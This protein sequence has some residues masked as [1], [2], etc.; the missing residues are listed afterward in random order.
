MGDSSQTTNSSQQTSPWAQAMPTVNALFGGVNS[1]LGNTGLTGAQSGAI[2]QLTQMGHAGN[3][4]AGASQ[5]ALDS[6]LHGGG[7]QTYSPMV[8][9]AYNTYQGQT[10]PL[11]SNTNYDPMQTPGLGDQLQALKDSITTG[12]NGQFAAAGRDLSGYNQK[13]LGSGLSAGLA[14]ILTQQY[15]QNVQNQQ[16]AAANQFGAGNTEANTLA[17]MQQQGVNNQNT[18]INNTGTVLNNSMWGPQTTLTA[19][20]L[21]HS[22]PTSNLAS[23][24]NIGIPLASLGSNSS[25]T[26]TTQNSP[27]LIQDLTG[28]S[29]ALGSG[30]SATSGGSG[31]LALLGML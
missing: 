30:K 28:I 2:D 17:G 8:Q 3:P 18:G 14:P 26:S 21:L 27:S 1:Q 29:G 11:A 10:N 7:A 19:Q 4:Y 31:I 22:I 16:Q 6:M 20:Q 9:Q 25:G 13:A 5:T 24:A 12:V 15:N 23:L